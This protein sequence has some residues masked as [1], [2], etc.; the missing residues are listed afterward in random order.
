MSIA[1]KLTQIA[2]NEQKVY[3]AGKK[4][5]YDEFWDSFQQ[6]KDAAS[7]EC[8]FQFWIG[9]CFKPKHDIKIVGQHSG[10]NAFRGAKGFNLK[11]MTVDRGVALDVSEATRLLSTFYGTQLYEIPPLDLK[12]CTRIE[13]AFS[14]MMYSTEKVTLN[15]IK[16]DCVFDKAFKGTMGLKSLTITGTI[17]QD[18]FDVSS[19]TKLT[20]DSIESIVDAL[21][22]T[23]TGKT[24]TL[25]K[26]AV[27][28]AF[29][30]TEWDTLESTKTN[31]TISLV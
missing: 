23:A 17:G 26:T 22:N 24:L 19:C 3:E 8:A 25:S 11:E 28:N 9:A 5:E 1:E 20:R 15:N 13:L 14:N 7:Y 18:G 2:E 29:T 6:G 4:S 21:S 12:S 10:T 27:E 16:A 31:W 30:D